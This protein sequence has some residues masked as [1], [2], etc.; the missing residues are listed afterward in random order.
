MSGK[1]SRNEKG[2]V[3]FAL[4]ATLL[5][6]PGF[7]YLLARIPFEGVKSINQNPFSA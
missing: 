5:A 7:G 4:A 3:I 1:P 6:G 2:D